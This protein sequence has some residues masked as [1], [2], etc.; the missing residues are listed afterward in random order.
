[1]S[2]SDT[3]TVTEAISMLGLWG[4]AMLDASRAAEEGK[5]AFPQIEVDEENDSS[6]EWGLPL[7]GLDLSALAMNGFSEEE[8]DALGFSALRGTLGEDASVDLVRAGATLSWL[9]W[10]ALRGIP[11]GTFFSPSALEFRSQE[12]LNTDFPEPSPGRMT[13]LAGRSCE[14]GEWKLA[15]G[16]VLRLKNS[17]RAAS[18]LQGEEGGAQWDA[19]CEQLFSR[20]CAFHASSNF[21]LGDARA[22]AW[23]RRQSSESVRPCL[24]ALFPYPRTCSWG[25]LTLS[26]AW[27]AIAQPTPS[28]RLEGVRCLVEGAHRTLSFK[29][30][31]LSE[32]ASLAASEATF[33]SRGWA[34]MLPRELSRLALFQLLLPLCDRQFSEWEAAAAAAE[35]ATRDNVE[36]GY[37]DRKVDLVRSALGIALVGEGVE[38]SKPL[39][40]SW[41]AA[42]IPCIID[43][44]TAWD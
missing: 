30:R 4:S 18:G 9:V 28:P 36:R 12:D 37:S 7:L 20:G 29:V 26:R 25:G 32:A 41:I 21:C 23:G 17:S 15:C 10:C 40:V 38:G 8:A 19:Q 14:G 43:A 1:M 42:A 11:S 3:V 39:L 5:S 24:L 35:A 16:G 27:A 33:P 34:S 13:L 31:A 44:L 6:D 2:D 22:W